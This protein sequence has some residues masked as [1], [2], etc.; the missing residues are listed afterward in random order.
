MFSKLFSL[1]A[2]TAATVYA[3]EPDFALAFRRQRADQTIT[4]NEM[5]AFVLPMFT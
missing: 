3:Q 4:I 5:N 1:S 2:F